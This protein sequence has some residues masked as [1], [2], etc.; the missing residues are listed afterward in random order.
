MKI[1]QEVEVLSRSYVRKGGKDNRRQQRARMLVFA[2][3]CAGEGAHSLAQ[4][5]AAHVIRYWR[6]NIHLSDST[7]YNHWRAFCVLWLLCG[8]SVKPP[9]PHP[10]KLLI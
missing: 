6:A 8:K 9:K 5:G 3:F 10:P 1:L 7:R 4:V 2:E